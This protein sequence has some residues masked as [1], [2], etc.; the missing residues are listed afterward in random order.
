MNWI[1]FEVVG[2]V[3]EMCLKCD[4]DRSCKIFVFGKK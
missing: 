3:I 2:Y 1:F 4:S